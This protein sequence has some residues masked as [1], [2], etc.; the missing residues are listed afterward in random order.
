[1]KSLQH[2]LKRFVLGFIAIFFL[3][4]IYSQTGNNFFGVPISN[5]FG[6]ASNELK[7]KDFEIV[8]YSNDSIALTGTLMPFGECSVVLY[9]KSQTIT[10]KNNSLVDSAIKETYGNPITSEGNKESYFISSYNCALVVKDD[11]FT[12]I[13][14]IDLSDILTIKF[15]G[16]TLGR[17]LK[18]ILPL[19]KKDF[20]YLTQFQGYTILTGKFAG[21]SDCTIYVNAVDDEEIVS[22][23]NVLFP[24]TDNWNV[25]FAQYNKLKKS[26][27]EKYG[28]PN[29]CLEDVVGNKKNKIKDLINGDV[30]CRTIFKTSAV[31]EITLSLIG[32]EDVKDVK[33]AVNVRYD[34]LLSLEKKNKSYEN[35]L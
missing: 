13:V 30:N 28:E 32:Y 20:N 27:T 26:L 12:K 29:E 25:L 23:V 22:F 16:I 17:P 24:Q 33:G 18:E 14:I 19:L 7:K 11:L 6:A 1:M 4:A 34:D 35:D 3:N 8:G 31:G 15:K 21:Y 10:F 9:E 5:D 2:N